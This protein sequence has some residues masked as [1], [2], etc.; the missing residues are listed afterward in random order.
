M[1]E[2]WSRTLHLNYFNYGY[3]TG[4]QVCRDF[5]KFL[6]RRSEEFFSRVFLVF[7]MR[8]S[9]KR[10]RKQPGKLMP[11]SRSQLVNLPGAQLLMNPLGMVAI[12]LIP[13][14]P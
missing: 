6:C 11:K 12:S 1:Q 5:I 14:S 4:Y 13:F 3:Q 10:R 7:L 8:E 9:K 2:H